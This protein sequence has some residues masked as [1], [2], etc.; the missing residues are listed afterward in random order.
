M[1]CDAMGWSEAERGAPCT[2]QTSQ[3]TTAPHMDGL[4]KNQCGAH[5]RRPIYPGL[6][7]WTGI[8]SSHHR[9]CLKSLAM[10]V[11]YENIKGSTRLTSHFGVGTPADLG[12]ADVWPGYEAVMVRRPREAGSGDEAVPQREALLGRFGLI[13]HWATDTKL[14]KSTYNARSETVAVKP[15][16]RDAWKHAQHCIISAEA[17]YEPDWRSGKAVSARICRSDGAPMG[18]AGLYSHWKDPKGGTIY[19]FT[20]L[21]IN[22]DQHSF[23]NQFHKPTDEKRMVVVLNEDAYQAWLEAPADK[24][25]EFM[26]AFNANRLSCAAPSALTT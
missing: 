20:L 16:F 5:L 9:L 4:G 13:P 14:T 19:S 10:C 23:M 6:V 24:S 21:T 18:L 7:V 8:R 11:H 3:Q 22:A 25:M 17:I 2:A 12:K 15:S 26:R 1:R